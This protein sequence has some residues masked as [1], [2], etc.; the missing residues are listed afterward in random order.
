MEHDGVPQRPPWYAACAEHVQ[1]PRHGFPLV[2]SLW[3]FQETKSCLSVCAMLT[4][5]MT[6]CFQSPAAFPTEA[7]CNWAGIVSSNHAT[8]TKQP[9]NATSGQTEPGRFCKGARQGSY[10]RKPLWFSFVS[11]LNSVRKVKLWSFH[12]PSLPSLRRSH[13][14]I[15]GS[16][17]I[18]SSM[19]FL[20]GNLID[21]RIYCYPL[22][23]GCWTG[24]QTH[25]N[26]KPNPATAWN[27]ALLS[28]LLHLA[29]QL[30]AAAFLPQEHLA[31]TTRVCDAFMQKGG[32]Q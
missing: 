30:P 18:I 27:S 11:I 25:G 10:H 16:L 3:F 31:W 24:W 29:L 1:S 13:I 20:S 21:G 15:F 23:T 2:G 14:Q 8:T 32:G 9:N 7:R 6:P 26:S 12:A 22:S 4:E 19:A 17:Q 5:Q 28:F